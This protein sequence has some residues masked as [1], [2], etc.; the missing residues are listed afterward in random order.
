M[1]ASGVKV[2][3]ER[4]SRT[5]ILE[6]LRECAQQ[7]LDWDYLSTC[8]NTLVSENL[9]FSSQAP[10]L[11]I[12]LPES[13]DAWDD[14]DPATHT[15][16][17]YFMCDT[18]NWDT[19]QRRLPKHIHL[20]DHEG[21]SIKR[22]EE[23][24]Q[25]YGDYVLR[26]LDAVKRGYSDENIDIPCL[27]TFQILWTH[28]P[29]KTDSKLSKDTLRLLVDKAIA[30]FR[31]LP[32]PE[33]RSDLKLSRSQSAMVKTFLN[34]QDGDNTEGNLHRHIEPSQYVYWRCQAHAQQNTNLES[35]SG[36]ESFV[37]SHRGHVD[38]QQSTLKVELR[39]YA[40]AELFTTLLTSTKHVFNI[41]IKLYWE[42]TQ[43][44][45]SQLCRDIA[46]TKSVSL[47]IDGV[48]LKTHTQN[49]VQD[50][51]SFFGN[52]ILRTTTIP[53]LTLLNTPQPQRR[54]IYTGTCALETA[55]TTTPQ[56]YN[57]PELR[58]DL[59]K[60][61]VLFSVAQSTSNCVSA[62]KELRSA[63]INR[64]LPDVNV[65][66]IHEAQWEA[67]C[68][69]ENGTPVVMTL[70][71]ADYDTSLV[72]VGAL[73]RLTVDIPDPEFAS[74]LD[75]IVRAN[76]ALERLIVR[77]LGGDE[78][79]QVSESIA[80]F[81][82]NATDMFHVTLYER[83]AD[84]GDRAFVQVGFDGKNCDWVDPFK[85]CVSPEDCPSYPQHQAEGFPTE[86]FI[87]QWECDHVPLLRSDNSA[88]VLD[89]ASRQFPWVLT[90]LVLD[91]SGLSKVGLG[92]VE[93]VLR[94][95]HLDHLTV[96]CTPVDPALS[97]YIAETL[98]AVQWP[99]LK[100]LLLF[101]G[102]IDEWIQLWATSSE[103][104]V[105]MNNS[106]TG[107]HLL[108]VYLQ[109]AGS[110]S[111][112]LSH[113]SVLFIHRLIQSSPLAEMYFQR[114][115]LQDK[116]DWGIIVESIEPLLLEALGLCQGSTTQLMDVR[117]AWEL[118]QAKFEIAE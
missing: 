73:E 104:Q 102:H 64:G 72:N 53:I 85:R 59:N 20:S 68:E 32:P 103:T 30:Y 108:R 50:M 43:L 31:K 105:V 42:P 78:L 86:I 57:W 62:S 114:V 106:S 10:R 52:N 8:N 40:D 92:S 65:V 54:Y 34:V 109:A 35:L 18:K 77:V 115:L 88:F 2:Q 98:Q 56:E 16:R 33:S 6:E 107:P 113:T 22:P 13:L 51:A 99:T 39:S 55:L 28:G 67:T 1:D 36:I 23:F 66:R 26:I 83:I 82:K 29:K 87:Q 81:W 116:R 110:A 69:I 90:S 9:L 5:Q 60:F 117:E 12:V 84:R 25:A 101:G 63:L 111:Q 94:Q 4:K 95:S 37:R 27:G 112:L 48:I 97:E 3:L 89:W 96:M 15:F 76:A 21:Y 7:D 11:F 19:R 38:V 58:S 91:V 74:E 41:S 100:S 61:S 14:L 93:S 24:M 79:F 75:S 17:L 71:N 80:R 45:L 70:F 49:Q 118:F 44:Q 47:E 46:K